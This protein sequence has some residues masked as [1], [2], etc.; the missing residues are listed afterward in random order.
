MAANPPIVRVAQGVTIA[1]VM[2]AANLVA[3]YLGV[4]EKSWLQRSWELLTGGG[5]GLLTGIGFFVLFGAVGLVSGPVYG[6]IGLLGLAAG[7]TLGGLGLGALLNVIRDPEKYNIS[8]LTVV[9]VLV[10]GAAIAGW[11]AHIVGRKFP[12][13]APS[14]SDA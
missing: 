7:G 10:V 14:Q 9:A 4:E 8:Y 3:Y 6:A 2:C 1:V 13:S 11:L 12:G 5:I